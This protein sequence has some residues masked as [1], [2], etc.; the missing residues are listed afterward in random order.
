[1]AATLRKGGDLSATDRSY[2]AKVVAARTNIGPA[3]AEKRVSD[4]IAQAKKATDDARR[5]TAK[6]MLWVAASM[7][8]G[9]LASILG[10]AEGG[11]LR[12]SKW[13]EPGWRASHVRNH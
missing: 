12:D 7:L 11:V 9:A 6:L 13:Y 5:A 1:M 4:T 2:V 8:A 10:A 3:E